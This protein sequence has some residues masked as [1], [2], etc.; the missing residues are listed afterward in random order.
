MAVQ[1]E[2]W[3]DINCPF[4]YLG[5]R[6]FE[7]ALAEFAHRDE[8]RV[9]HRSFEL[10]PTLPA[11]HSGPVVPHIAHKYGIS[12]A[13]AA[14]NERGIGAQAE[15]MGLPY[16]T[17]GRDFGNSFDMHR[18]L[19]YA[20]AHGRQEQLL[21]ALYRGNFAEDRPLFADTERLIE[22]A[23]QA[24]LDETDVRAVLAD[25]QAYADAVRADEQEAARLGATGVPFFV[26][27]RKY[28]VSGAQPPEVFA[29]A[30]RQAWSDHAPVLEVVGGGDACGP[31][32]CALPE[33]D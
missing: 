6:R 17:S 30:L 12:E 26:F 32:G 25:P 19:H 13:Q 29:Q 28:G 1:V 23:G 7:T 10:D 3:T 21:D 20:L 14:A 24:G 31:D 18:L 5:K 22:L 8:V 33:R 15:A 16:Q 9:V 11:E 4:C 27:D 2:I